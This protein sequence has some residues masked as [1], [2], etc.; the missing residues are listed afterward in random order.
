MLRNLYEFS[1]SIVDSQCWRYHLGLQHKAE[2]L[3]DGDGE[4]FVYPV[5]SLLKFERI[6]YEFWIH[7]LPAFNIWAEARYSYLSQNIP[8][9]PTS[10]SAANFRVEVEQ[11]E[12]AIAVA[13]PASVK[14]ET[15]LPIV[16]IAN[17]SVRPI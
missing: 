12:V 10:T 15:S 7:I 11:R 1:C 4:G 8:T 3:V 14:M 9:S 16:A 2:E 13:A 6:Y 17:E 5:V